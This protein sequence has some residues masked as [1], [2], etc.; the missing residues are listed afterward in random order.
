MVVLC[1]LVCCASFL[2]VAR[3]RLRL[4]LQALGGDEDDPDILTVNATFSGF[5][6]ESLLVE[7]GAADG[8]DD[9]GPR[10]AA[11]F[12]DGLLTVVSAECAGANE[13]ALS[14]TVTVVEPVLVLEGVEAEG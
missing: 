11:E 10:S 13:A 1:V 14:G 12:G 3:A 7:R 6:G 5:L 2:I 9:A 8:P 4:R